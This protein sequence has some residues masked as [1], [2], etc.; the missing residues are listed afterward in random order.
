MQQSHTYAFI[1][2]FCFPIAVDASLSLFVMQFALMDIEDLIQ[3]TQ[4]HAS[5]FTFFSS[6]SVIVISFADNK[7]VMWKAF[8]SSERH[9]KIRRT[10]RL[11][12]LP[13]CSRWLSSYVG[14]IVA[15]V[16]IACNAICVLLLLLLFRYILWQKKSF[17]IH[18]NKKKWMTKSLQLLFMVWGVF[19]MLRHK[20]SGRCK[21]KKKL[22]FLLTIF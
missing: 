3:H 7:W 13:R 20:L 5:L 8:H 14:F 10:L 17:L 4:L 18:L 22:I 12:F 19:E 2:Q 16:L 9:R 21:I 15:Y 6:L 1:H 11:F